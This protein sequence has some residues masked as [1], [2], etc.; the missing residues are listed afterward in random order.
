MGNIEQEPTLN[1]ID[2]HGEI[3]IDD[4]PQSGLVMR[5]NGFQ[6][7]PMGLIVGWNPSFEQWEAVGEKLRQ[8]ER[9]VQFWIGDW[10]NYGEKRWGDKF[11][12]AIDEIGYTSGSL[13]NMKW[14]SGRVDFSSRNDNLTYA[15]HV[16]VAPL[17]TEQQREWLDFAEQ[18]DLSAR[19][20]RELI[21]KPMLPKSNNSKAVGE[22]DHTL[23]RITIQA[24]SLSQ[25]N[26]IIEATQGLVDW[27]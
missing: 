13:A 5:L 7:T 25:I 17:P 20:L 18:N 19:K 21:C 16:T 27:G 8:I 2:E 12:Q 9:A 10:L 1:I 14:V 26:T 3:I 24:N 15:H 22:I 4:E 6:F 23:L 11:A